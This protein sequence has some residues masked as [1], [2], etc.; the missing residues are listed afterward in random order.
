ME[1][2]VARDV[3]LLMLIEASNILWWS[4]AILDEHLQ[5]CKAEAAMQYPQSRDWP[6]L[7]WPSAWPGRLVDMWVEWS[8]A[9]VCINFEMRY[10]LRQMGGD[11]DKAG[12]A[13]QGH[14]ASW[15]RPCGLKNPWVRKACWCWLEWDW[16][17]VI[18]PDRVVKRA[19]CLILM[20]D[21]Q[22]KR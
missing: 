12:Y 1:M 17:G 16:S 6:R 4:N 22:M 15:E 8:G 11:E 13:W 5:V 14:F 19:N 21:E 2:M 9:L 7:M 10:G 18:L 3:R 20:I